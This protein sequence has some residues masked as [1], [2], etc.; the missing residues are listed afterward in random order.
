MYLWVRASTFGFI[1]KATDAVFPFFAAKIFKISISGIDSTLKQ[2]ISLSNP[3]FISLSV[4]P[5]PA[6]TILD[7]VNPHSNALKISF[8]LTQSAPNPYD[9]ISLRMRGLELA[10]KA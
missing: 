10:F 3:I 9:D 6:K 1:L 5:T 7:G 4:L 2:K 8:P